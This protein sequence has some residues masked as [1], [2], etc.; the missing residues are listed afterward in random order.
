MNLNSTKRCVSKRCVSSDTGHA[1]GTC[2]R[3][4]DT[5]ASRIDFMY[6]LSD[7]PVEDGWVGEEKGTPALLT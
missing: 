5:L 4:I 3:R 7:M 1:A 2:S 6:F